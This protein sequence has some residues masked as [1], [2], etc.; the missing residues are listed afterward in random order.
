MDDDSASFIAGIKQEIVRINNRGVEMAKAGQLKEA[1]D[2]FREAVEGMPGNKVVNLNAARVLV[3]YMQQHGTD[4]EQLGI[5]R[6][7]LDR[8]RSQDPEN[9]ALR[10]VQGMYHELAG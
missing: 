9:Q 3:M 4:G 7:Y 6:S 2:L 8:V 10:R 1:V 5:V